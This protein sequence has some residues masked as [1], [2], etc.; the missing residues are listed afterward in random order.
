MELKKVKPWHERCLEVRIRRARRVRWCI[1]REEYRWLSERIVAHARRVRK[2]RTGSTSEW[3]RELDE[4]LRVMK[5]SGG[6]RAT[7]M[8][9][10]GKDIEPYMRLAINGYDEPLGVDELIRL[11]D[12]M[13]CQ[14]W[15]LLTP[16]GSTVLTRKG[17]PGYD[18]RYMPTDEWRHGTRKRKETRRWNRK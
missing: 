1:Q 15:E 14:P 5:K 2:E 17:D 16:I 10:V 13:G 18:T 7:R 11:A 9:P 4:I 8:F 6:T 3:W 12:W